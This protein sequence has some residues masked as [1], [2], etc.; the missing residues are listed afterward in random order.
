MCVY[1]QCVGGKGMS[2]C[3]GD[4]ILQEFYTG[5]GTSFTVYKNS[6]PPPRQKVRRGGGLRKI[7]SCRKV[8]FQVSFKTKI[9]FD[10]CLF[11]RYKYMWAQ[12]NFKNMRF[13]TFKFLIVLF[14]CLWDSFHQG[15]GERGKGG[16]GEGG[17]IGKA[18]SSL[19][20]SKCKFK[21]IIMQI[22]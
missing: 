4:H 5:Y 15:E 14:K 22:V 2:S 19:I 11:F 20:P 16:R 13:F 10:M 12:A 21:L 7:S 3:V 8:L 1:A 18:P 17:G 9:L 6:W